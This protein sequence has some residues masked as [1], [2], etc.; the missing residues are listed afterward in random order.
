MLTGGLRQRAAQLGRRETALDAALLY[1][2]DRFQRTSRLL[3]SGLSLAQSEPQ[4]NSSRRLR[5]PAPRAGEGPMLRTGR[6]AGIS[7][8]GQTRAARSR[9]CSLRRL[10]LQRRRELPARELVV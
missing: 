2:R 8:Q 10:R 5:K 9:S 3:I 6:G 4:T 1:I 7:G